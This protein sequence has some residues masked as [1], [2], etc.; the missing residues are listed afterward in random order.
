MSAISLFWANNWGSGVLNGTKGVLNGDNHTLGNWGSGVLNGTK[1]V[2]N[3]D[4]HT[5]GN[6][7]TLV[8]NPRMIALQPIQNSGQ[9]VGEAVY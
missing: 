4:N 1:G 2:L 5:S 7:C 8:T 9:K 3:G 6:V